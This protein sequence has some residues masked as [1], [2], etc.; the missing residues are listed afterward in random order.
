MFI[1]VNCKAPSTCFKTTVCQHFHVLFH[2][3]NNT[4]SDWLENF[5]KPTV[6]YKNKRPVYFNYC[7]M[8]ATN[9]KVEKK[10]VCIYVKREN[11]G[12]V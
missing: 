3:S 2:F 4:S 6:E 1:L 7:S 5:Y 10:K 9:I 11:V 8:R 12:K